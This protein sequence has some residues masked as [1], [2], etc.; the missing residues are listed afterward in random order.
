MSK[1]VANFDSVINDSYSQP[2]FAAL[3]NIIEKFFKFLSS[4][5]EIIHRK[6]YT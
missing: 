5:K 2:I 4:S 3:L 1:F 6:M